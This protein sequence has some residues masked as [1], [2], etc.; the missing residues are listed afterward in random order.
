MLSKKQIRTIFILAGIFLF[1]F[2]LLPDIIGLGQS[3]GFGNHQSI[4]MVVGIILM[5]IGWFLKKR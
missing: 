5:V 2:S 3:P 1:I 4:M